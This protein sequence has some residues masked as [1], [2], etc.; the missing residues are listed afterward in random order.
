MMGIGGDGEIETHL[1]NPNR[2]F[3]VLARWMLNL[4]I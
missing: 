4:G 2:G 3:P 1:D